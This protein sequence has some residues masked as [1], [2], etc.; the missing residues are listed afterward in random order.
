MF[1]K[2][3]LAVFILFLIATPVHAILESDDSGGAGG[4]FPGPANG[5]S[6]TSSNCTSKTELCNPLGSKDFGILVANIMKFIRNLVIAAVA[7]LMVVIGGIQILTAG[8]NPE[9]VTTGRK[10]IL[11]AL[12]GVV[13]VL[14]AEGLVS[15]IRDILGVTS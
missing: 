8:G 13:V 2:L 7:P 3:F 11:Y 14:V 10:T 15:L 5:N 6:G 9:Q 4:G 12:L 1:M